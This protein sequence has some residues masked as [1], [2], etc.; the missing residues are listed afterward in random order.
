MRGRTKK[1]IVREVKSEK[2]KEE[3]KRRERE[4]ERERER[5][6]RLNSDR[7]RADDDERFISR[8]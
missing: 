3:K 5:V 6:H 1:E 2:S 4:R 7:V 8:F